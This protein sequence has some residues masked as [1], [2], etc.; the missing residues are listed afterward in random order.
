MG[1]TIVYFA[2][3][4][5]GKHAI[6]VATTFGVA[7]VFVALLQIIMSRVAF[8][9]IQFRQRIKK[10]VGLLGPRDPCTVLAENRMLVFLFGS[11]VTSLMFEAVVTA[12][13]VLNAKN[14]ADTY[15]SLQGIIHAL[16]LTEHLL[17]VFY[18][19]PNPLLPFAWCLSAEE[20]DDDHDSIQ[21]TAS[22]P[23]TRS[24]S[25]SIS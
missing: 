14:S 4:E 9:I 2:G 23:S 3:K 15:I 25:A 19:E 7:I 22:S 11:L 17:V 18:L 6:S 16:I 20:E 12:A 13:F 8:G 5:R 21:L 24:Y 10:K 1:L